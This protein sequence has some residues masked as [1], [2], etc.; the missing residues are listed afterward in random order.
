MCI[1]VFAHKV[2]KDYPLVLL[3][4]RDE[5][6]ARP[7]KPIQDWH[8]ETGIVAG[9]DLQAGGTWLGHNAH[10]QW[11]AITNYRD[12]TLQDD[13][14]RSRGLIIT[15][16]LQSK[17]T[18]GSFCES[19][20]KEF[21]KYN[22]FNGLIADDNDLFYVSSRLQSLQRLSPGIYVLSNAHLDTPWPKAETLK[23]SFS[24]AIA[25]GLDETTLWP[26][27]LNEAKAPNESLPSTGIATELENA[28]SSIFIN[29]KNYGTRA[30]YLMTIS[31]ESKIILQEK[32]YPQ[33]GKL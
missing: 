11:A 10:Q 22:H 13:H 2:L 33:K 20:S 24:A 28:L 1:I 27:L 6:Y 29:L 8:N 12:P 32:V 5:E 7:T 30:S 21:S 4:N 9:K 19:L 31:S 17:Q 15:D 23:K 26:L 14:K 16:Y 18:A 25:Q 3:S